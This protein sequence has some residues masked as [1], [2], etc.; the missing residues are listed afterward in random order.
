MFK[1]T[2]RIAVAALM[3]AAVS[4]ASA[5]FTI[6]TAT[7]QNG[8]DSYAGTFDRRIG[9]TAGNNGDGSAVGEYVW[10]DGGS[11]ALNDTGVIQGLIRFDNIIGAGA[12]PTGAVILDANLTMKTA[13]S[14]N[15]Q[16]A[17]A[18][19]VY[20]MNTAFDGT[21]TYASL[22]NDGLTGDVTPIAG[23]FDGMTAV[24][25]VV[26]ARIDRAVQN[27][28]NGGTNTGLGIRSDRGTDGW[29]VE[30]TGAATAANRPLLTVNYTTSP[31]VVVRSLQQGVNGYTGTTDIGFTATVAT[32]NPPVYTTTVG[33]SVAEL[34]VDGAPDT[35]SPQAGSLD[36]PYLIKFANATTGLR[37]IVKAELVFV[38]G[39][40]NS[41]AD[42]EGPFSVH[43]LNVPFTSATTYADLDALNT[44]TND[45]A[46]TN[47]V[48]ELLVGGSI[49]PAVG[50]F[51]GINDT[52]VVAL[53]VTSVVQNWLNGQANHGFF[54][55]AGNTDNGWQLFTSG[56]L[57]PSFRPELRIIGIVPEPTTLVALS[58]TALL[59]LRRRR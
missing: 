22:G 28:A 4:A 23:S 15:A 43:Q 59:A 32:P 50:S 40:S 37:Q 12:I 51:V 47:V 48:G 30:T 56:A 11:S 57:D 41:A 3:L 42:S 13:G 46:V 20:Q 44:P 21:T 26:S 10:V 33:S 38:S 45:P 14:S 36:Q 52:E 54:I 24:N 8:V 25:T 39:F 17:N 18:I 58:A 34:F 16:S 49:N 53:D 19:N 29:Q 1:S 55:S 2:S 9:A 35:A 6:N 27:W 5:Q 31:D 7:F